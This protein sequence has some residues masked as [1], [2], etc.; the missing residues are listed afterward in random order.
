MKGKIYIGTSGW[1]YDHWRGIFYPEEVSKTRW[2]DYYAEHFDTVELNVSFY[3]LPKKE[4]FIGWW[5]K[6]P[7]NFLFAVKASRFITHVKR[8]KDCREPWK[9]FISHAKGLKEKL[10]PVLFQ[11]PPNLKVNLDRLESFLKIISKYKV[12][13][14]FEFRDESWFC[15]EVYSLLSKYKTA[16]VLADSPRYPLVEK[17]TADFVYIRFHGGKI[18]YGSNYSKKELKKWA[19]KIKKW[20]KKG[21]DVYAYFNNDAHGYAVDNAMTLKALTG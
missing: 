12:R 14:A 17:V 18:L 7:K 20:S 16:L 5:E 2:F 9:L 8:L 10:G 21:L 6:S 1:L 3:R 19:N 15:D 13:K 4:T 11:L